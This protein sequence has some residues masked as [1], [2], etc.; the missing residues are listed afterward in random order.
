MVTEILQKAVSRKDTCQERHPQPACSECALKS[1]SNTPHRLAPS[2]ARASALIDACLRCNRTTLAAQ[3]LDDLVERRST[4][5]R[6]RPACITVMLPLF[7]ILVE[8]TRRHPSVNFLART[9]LC[10][11][12]VQDALAFLRKTSETPK[13]HTVDHVLAGIQWSGE[14][15]SF[16]LLSVLHSMKPFSVSSK[17]TTLLKNQIRAFPT[18]MASK[19]SQG[20]SRRVI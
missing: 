8:L 15:D 6:T 4:E 3:V 17:L 5:P 2:P 20:H 18:Q 7:P 12:A 10:A 13:K 1:C 11:A 9:R 14:S 19:K 16:K